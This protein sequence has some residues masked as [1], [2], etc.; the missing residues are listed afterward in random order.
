VASSVSLSSFLAVRCASGEKV[1]S[2][3]TSASV[4]ASSW[5]SGTSSVTTPQSYA[6]FAGRRRERIT[7]SLVRVMPTIFCSRA[8]PPEPG[9]WPSFCSGSAYWAVSEAMRKSQASAISKPTPKQ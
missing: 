8:E 2:S 1:S 7:M 5:A 3:S 9:I 4:A 6:C